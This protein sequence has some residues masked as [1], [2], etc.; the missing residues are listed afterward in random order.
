MKVYCKRNYL[1]LN[2][3]A[4]V[5]YGDKFV[6]WKKGKIYDV[7]IPPEFEVEMGILYY[8][9]NEEIHGQPITSPVNKKIFHKYF[10]TIDKYRDIK[11]NEILESN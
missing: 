3:N 7:V 6:K 10:H 4:G 5:G 8:I 11:I 2:T 1:E 9:E